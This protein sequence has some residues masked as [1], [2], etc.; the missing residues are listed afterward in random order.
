M[1]TE[2]HY[3]ALKKME[4]A[5]KA[6]TLGVPTE[7]VAE[8]YGVSTTTINSWKR[9]YMPNAKT[10]E[11]LSE[12][13]LVEIDD[14]FDRSVAVTKVIAIQRIATLV[15][16]ETDIDKLSRLLKEL[17]TIKEGISPENKDSPWSQQVNIAIQNVYKNK[18]IIQNGG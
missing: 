8:E 1:E 6:V 16:G 13:S 10:L 12:M 17:R 14:N 7:E 4:A 18:N 11:E 2:K 9:K 15:P 5:N 3:P